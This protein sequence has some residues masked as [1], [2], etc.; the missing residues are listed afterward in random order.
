MMSE[1]EVVGQFDQM[2]KVIE[3]MLKGSTPSQISK[4]LGFKLSEVNEHI[5]NWKGL[6]LS[7]EFG[8]KERATE[9]LSAA[10]QHYNMIIKEAWETVH[11]ADAQEALNVKAQ[12]LKLIADVEQKRIDMLQ[13]AG[14]LEKNDMADAI[15][16]TERKQEV[17]V[18]ILRDVTSSCSHCK[19]E[20][21][22]RLS[23]VTN[24]VEV[25]SID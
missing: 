23:E 10:D 15:L 14:V 5:K 12:S 20:V 4:S 8:I 19:Q 16:E 2:N 17:L 21:A 13:K 1:L 24:R 7:G 22:R 18:G 25:I 3:E 9:A 6:V 11:Q